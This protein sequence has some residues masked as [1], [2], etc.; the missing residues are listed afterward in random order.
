VSQSGFCSFRHSA[1]WVRPTHLGRGPALLS[2]LIQML[3]SSR[4]TLTDIPRVMF[5]KISGNP[6]T[7]ASQHTKWIITLVDEVIEKS[8]NQGRPYWETVA[9][10]LRHSHMSILNPTCTEAYSSEVLYL[11]A[12]QFYHWLCSVSKDS[13]DW[14]RHPPPHSHHFRY[15]Y[16]F[17][18]HPHFW[19]TGYKFEDSN[20]FFWL[21]NSL[22]NS[23]DHETVMIIAWN[24][25]YQM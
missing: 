23:E 20:Y 25:N 24:L 15:P 11:F 10:Y 6:R 14:G 5:S 1:V 12:M 19:T 9:R 16:V 18:G 8:D 4:N 22:D 2:L 21:D 7:Q 17:P 13:T 3:I